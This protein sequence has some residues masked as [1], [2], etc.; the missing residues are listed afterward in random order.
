[1]HIS[2]KIR[3]IQLDYYNLKRNKNIDKNQD[4]DK[5][6]IHKEVQL[7]KEHLLYYFRSKL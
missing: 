2:D 5:N 7:T 6:E 3:Q 4:I 1:M